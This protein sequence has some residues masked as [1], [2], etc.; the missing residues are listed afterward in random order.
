MALLLANLSCSGEQVEVDIPGD[1]DVVTESE[2]HGYTRLDFVIAGRPGLL[3]LPTES[4][5]GNPW[6]WRAEWFGDKHAPEV[7][8]EMLERGWA[9]AYMNAR[10]MYGGPQAM[11]LF[12]A[13][14]R[15][16]TARYGLSERLVMEGFSRGGLYAINFA[17]EYPERVAALYLDAPAIDLLSWPGRSHGGWQA[18]LDSY[19]IADD[20][21]SIAGVNPVNRIPEL[22]ESVIPVIGVSGD[23][24]KSVPYSENLALLREQYEAAGATIKVIIKP[25]VGHNHVLPDPG[26]VVEFLVQESGL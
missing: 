2:W 3:V 6:I 10:D 19:G 16:V 1:G 15:D 23:R 24:D 13:Y 17:L 20:A 7:E 14:Y 25:G 18:C 4:A 22:I 11:R 21:A 26:V 8:L 12:D 5:S 9:V